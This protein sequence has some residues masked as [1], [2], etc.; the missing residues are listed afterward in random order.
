MLFLRT[1]G[2][3]E[4]DKNGND[5]GAVAQHRGRLAVLAVLA[6]ATDRGVS[7]DRLQALFWPESDSARARNALNQALYALRRGLANENEELTLGTTE[8]Q[9]N[10]AVI[11]TDV[12]TFARLIESG[13]L[14]DAVAL[15]RGAFLDGIHIKE[16]PDFDRWMDAERGRLAELYRL[17]LERMAGEARV[18][19]K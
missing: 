1:F 7:R 2:G 11:Q 14:A 19:G 16:A 17:T 10:P 9:L 13:A 5:L 3:L 18:A 12:G 8:L 15:Y 4:L 6:A